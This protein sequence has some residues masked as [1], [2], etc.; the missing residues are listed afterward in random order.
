MAAKL[1]DLLANYAR[2]RAMWR[3]DGT[4]EKGIWEDIKEIFSELEEALGKHKKMMQ[5]FC[6]IIVTDDHSIRKTMKAR[7][8][9]DIVSIF[10]F[11]NKMNILEGLET[12]ETKVEKEGELWDYFRCM[13]GTIA[14]AKLHSGSCAARAAVKEIVHKVNEIGLEG[15]HGDPRE[16]CAG[17]DYDTL[18]IGST[19]F[20]KTMGDWI[21]TWKQ[22]HYGRVNSREGNK[23]CEGA[24]GQR[25]QENAQKKVHDEPVMTAL[26]DGTV[27]SIR[28][29]IENK[30]AIG[31]DQKKKIM[32]EFKNTG[33][34]GEAWKK[35][36]DDIGP[37]KTSV[38]PAAAEKP[39]HPANPG[40]T[41]TPAT[42][43]PQGPTAAAT[44]SASVTSAE[45]T[46]RMSPGVD[47]VCVCGDGHHGSSSG[48]EDDWSVQY[49]NL[50]N[51]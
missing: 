48:D 39:L 2:K 3:Q 9:V 29:M 25:S 49:T 5:Q 23:D 33:T 6:T 44:I 47:D 38:T 32:E 41:T 45:R 14:I 35:I 34:G 16:V 24:T 8:C 27:H 37:G 50:W 43:S 17:L 21:N 40:A 20:G 7:I 12:V 11:M 46:G 19:F 42:A 31:D 22:I 1:G 36:L 28:K 4:Y 51:T 18:K 26:E 30:E 10:S 13:V 15:G